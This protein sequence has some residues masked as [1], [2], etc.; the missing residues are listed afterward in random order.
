[1]PLTNSYNS[2]AQN[3]EQPEY[4]VLW[5]PIAVNPASS[6]VVTLPTAAGSIGWVPG[7]VLAYNTAGVGATPGPGGTRELDLH[8]PVR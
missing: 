3:N 8:G 1:M 2:L 6:A 7:C 4:Q 5:E